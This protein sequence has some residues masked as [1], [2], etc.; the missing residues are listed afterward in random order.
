[1][2]DSW[3]NKFDGIIKDLLS[4]ESTPENQKDNFEYL[5]DVI[6][7]L[8]A[9]PTDFVSLMHTQLLKKM[10]FIT[11]ILEKYFRQV[12]CVIVDLPCRRRN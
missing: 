2:I 9:S 8:R 10:N 5:D 12:P 6:K 7:E 11:Y 4:E 3:A 1:M